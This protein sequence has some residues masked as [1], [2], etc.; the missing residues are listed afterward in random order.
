MPRPSNKAELLADSVKKYDDLCSLLAGL[1]LEQ[2]IRPGVT[3]EW[4]AKDILAHLVEWQN[5]LFGWYE[6]GRRGEQP[7]VPATG[8]KWSEMPA[9][10]RQIYLQYCDAPLERVLEQFH[11]G[12]A[13]TLALMESL[14]EE[15]LFTPGLYAWM[16]RNTLSAYLKSAA[17]SHYHWARNEIRKYW[18]ANAA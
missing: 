9:L 3:G 13:R 15:E 12:H 6:A 7:A 14:S 4:S 17:G 10:N 16:N 5:M 2:M 18:R 1:S 11:A 8:F